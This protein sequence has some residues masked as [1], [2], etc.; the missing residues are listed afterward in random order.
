MARRND[1]RLIVGSVCVT[2]LGDGIA[3]VVLLLY[4]GDHSESGLVVASLLIALWAPMVVLAPLAGLLVDRLETR[5]LLLW[6][7][8]AQAAVVVAIAFASAVGVIVALTALLGVGMALAQPAEFA[9]I[10]AVA[11]H[12]RIQEANGHVETARYLGWLVGPMIGGLLAAGG[13]TRAALL[14]DAATFVAVAVAAWALVARRAPSAEREGETPERARDGLLFLFRDPLLAVIMAV[15]FVSLLFFSSST[16]AELFFATDVLDAG[17]VG[18]GLLIT[19]WTVG[20]GIGATLVARR[21]PGRLLAGAALAAVAVQGIGMAGATAYLALG[22][23]MVGFLIGGLGHG[24]KNVLVRTLVH[25]RVPKRLHGRAFAAYN[26]VRNSAELIALAS[27]G[28]LVAG[29]GARTSL[30]IAGAA[31]I[32]AAVAGLVALRARRELLAAEARTA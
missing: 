24:T 29:V 27:G 11:G 14:I 23:A 16:V 7:S 8:L 32:L 28:A 30:L 6:V 9:L 15:A 17:E 31:P 19:A 4:V 1:L 10:P 21:V 2:A 25:E 20:M 13:G 12:E 3:Y 5:T 22:A 18:Y 26:G